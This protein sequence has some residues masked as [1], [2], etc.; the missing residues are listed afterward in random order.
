MLCDA[1]I[2][3]TVDIRPKLLRDAERN[4]LAIA[5]FLVSLLIRRGHTLQS[6]ELTNKLTSKDSE[7]FAL[8][9]VTRIS[10][11]AENPSD[12]HVRTTCI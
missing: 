12:A 11:V 3:E 6:S 5:K 1:I 2:S 10:A 9:F 7:L 8:V 4:L